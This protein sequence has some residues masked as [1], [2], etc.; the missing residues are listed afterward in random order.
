MRNHASAYGN[1]YVNAHHNLRANVRRAEVEGLAGILRHPSLVHHDKLLDC[2]VQLIAIKA[3]Q[4]YDV[5]C[6]VMM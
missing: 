6:A 5:T 4:Q 2:L 1:T 3:L